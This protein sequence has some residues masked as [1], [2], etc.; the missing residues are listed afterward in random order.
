VIDLMH[1]GNARVIG[2][3]QVDDVVIDPGP[4]SSVETLLAA[5]GDE[6]PLAAL[7]ER[8]APVRR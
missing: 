2:C 5:L 8:A 1:L 3:W 6:R 4:S 7:L